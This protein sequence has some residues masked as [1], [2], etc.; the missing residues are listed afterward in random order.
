MPWPLLIIYSSIARRSVVGREADF[1]VPTV[2]VMCVYCVYVCVCVFC[3]FFQVHTWV[4][5]PQS[6]SLG[7]GHGVRKIVVWRLVCVGVFVCVLSVCVC[8]IHGSSVRNWPCKDRTLV[9]VLRGAGG[10]IADLHDRGG[11]VG[12]SVSASADVR[13][14]TTDRYSFC[15]LLSSLRMWR[16]SSRVCFFR[17]FSSSSFRCIWRFDRCVM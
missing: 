11:V 6:R 17:F 7:Q 14:S 3:S 1:F 15:L 12:V 10:V 2:C 9:C 8:L 16:R 13:S 5:E 4:V